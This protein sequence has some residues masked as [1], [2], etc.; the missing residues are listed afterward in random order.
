MKKI[1]IAGI[2]FIAFLGVWFS[3]TGRAQQAP[4]PGVL[5][6]AAVEKEEVDGD[7]KGAIALYMQII[8]KHSGN[9]AVAARALY[10]LGLCHERLGNQEARTAYR[11]II[12]QYPGQEEQ[13][14]LAKARLTELDAASANASRKPTFRKIRIPANPGNGVLSPRE[15]FGRSRSRGRCRQ[16]SP[17]NRSD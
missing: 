9:A 14:A 8:E 13:V 16:T 6:R 4:D 15:A 7:L 3:I 2:A 11:R 17:G 5:L 10:H 12:D 1:L